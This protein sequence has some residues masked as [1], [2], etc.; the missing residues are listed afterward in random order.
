MRLSLAPLMFALAAAGPAH[1]VFAQDPAAAL[2]SLGGPAAQTGP[3][4]LQ[5]HGFKVKFRNLWIKP[6]KQ[7]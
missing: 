1:T 7:N 4:M 6:L 2:V 3:I 5:D